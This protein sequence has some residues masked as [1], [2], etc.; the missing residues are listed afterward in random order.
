MVPH[1]EAQP[2]LRY[3]PAVSG[4]GPAAHSVVR[5]LGCLVGEAHGVAE[6]VAGHDLFLGSVLEDA[7]HFE[8]G[9]VR[10]DAA[11]PVRRGLF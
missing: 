5:S 1:W 2:G 4:E 3:G 11:G 9:Q 7:V 10:R 6:Q 8:G